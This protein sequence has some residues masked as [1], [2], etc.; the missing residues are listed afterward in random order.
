MSDHPPETNLIQEVSKNEHYLGTNQIKPL[1]EN[2][3]EPE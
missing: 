2:I 3:D 1:K